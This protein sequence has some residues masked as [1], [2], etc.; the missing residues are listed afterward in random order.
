MVL[1]L[2][3]WIK[4]KVVHRPLV[5]AA[6]Y[7]SAPCGLAYG[8]PIDSINVIHLLARVVFD[9]GVWIHWM[10]GWIF[11]PWIDTTRKENTRGHSRDTLLSKWNDILLLSVSVRST[12]CSPSSYS[13]GSPKPNPN[14]PRRWEC[15]GVKRILVH[16]S[17]QIARAT[18]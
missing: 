5:S 11:A 13:S 1:V 7:L 2:G 18:S 10:G 14:I 17:L 4:L 8:I 9:V 15:V 3:L 16:L 6:S 12:N